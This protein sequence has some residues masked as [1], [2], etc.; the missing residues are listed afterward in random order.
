MAGLIFRHQ[1]GFIQPSG[2][3]GS[4]VAPRLKRLE[5]RDTL[6]RCFGVV[7]VPAVGR[8]QSVQVHAIDEGFLARLF[9]AGGR[10]VRASSFRTYPFRISAAML[11]ETRMADSRTESRAR[12]AYRAVVSTWA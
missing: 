10:H 12:C 3:E 9:R 4:A 8:R 7:A 11:S 5:S 1:R 2:T 6:R